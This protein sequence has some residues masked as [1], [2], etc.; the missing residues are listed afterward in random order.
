[1]SFRVWWRAVRIRRNRRNMSPFS[2]RE[3]AELRVE[4]YRLIDGDRS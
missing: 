4:M 2:S 1:M 3:L